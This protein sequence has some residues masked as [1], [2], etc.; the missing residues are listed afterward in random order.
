MKKT[1]ISLLFLLTILSCTKEEPDSSSS[2]NQKLETDNL[3]SE[4]EALRQEVQELRDLLETITIVSD[5]DAISQKL[6]DLNDIKEEVG[7]LTSYYFEVDG[8]RFDKNGNVVST[9]KLENVVV[10]NGSGNSTLTTTRTYDGEG[11]LIELMK[12][13]SNYSMG[14]QMLPYRWK[15]EIYEYNGKTLITTIRT[16]EYG[17]PAGQDY[18]ETIT[19]KEYW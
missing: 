3:L 10:E 4:I 1:F 6:D 16:D 8:L 9:P 14:G 2:Q 17:L 13:Y 18:E 7:E 12:K 19:T 5:L 11:R 15:Q